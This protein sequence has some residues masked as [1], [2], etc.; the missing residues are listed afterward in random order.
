MSTTSRPLTGRVPAA[1]IGVR[2]IPRLEPAVL[3]SFRALGDLT[4]L[5]SDALDLLGLSGVVPA[6]VLRP[7]DP[8]ARLV[9]QAITLHNRL[10]SDVPAD[11]VRDKDNRLGDI[12]AHNLA[13]AGDVLVIQGADMVS[14]MGG[15]SAA[16]GRRQGESGA[17]VDGAVR[18]INTSRA[19][20]YPVWSR[21]VSPITG[22]WRLETVGVNVPIDIAGIRVHPGDLVV[23]D[24]IGV[25]FV[26]FDRA[27]E[28]LKAAQAIAAAEAK[29]QAHI[30]SGAS[31]QDLAKR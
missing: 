14:S 29:R 4:G 2:E 30:A 12:E 20:G 18:D 23:A 16:I 22:K 15:L 26:P 13:E 28:V 8:A 19:L 25:C 7:T 5:L 9:A 31:L 1:C 21:S 27:A 11:A 6:S 17:I 24:E 10:R 3:E